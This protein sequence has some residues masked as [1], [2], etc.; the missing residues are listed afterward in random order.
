[1]GDQTQDY[2]NLKHCAFQVNCLNVG[3]TFLSHVGKILHGSTIGLR[4]AF[5]FGEQSTIWC[6][7]HMRRRILGESRRWPTFDQCPRFTVNRAREIGTFE[8]L[9]CSSHNAT[10]TDDKW[11]KM[12]SRWPFFPKATPRSRQLHTGLHTDRTDEWRFL[13]LARR[14]ERLMVIEYSLFIC[15][16]SLKRYS[17]PDDDKN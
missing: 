5:E 11:T 17:G 3:W 10:V 8:L 15:V 2:F 6:F 12:K 16:L 1:M 13:A 4:T 7:F 14:D 9:N